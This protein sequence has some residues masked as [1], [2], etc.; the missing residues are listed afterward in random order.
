M[1]LLGKIAER[2][3]AKVGEFMA[4]HLEPG[5]TLVAALPMTQDSKAAMLGV[6][7]GPYFGLA[8][9]DRRLFVLKWR[10]TVPE[11][12]EEVLVAAPLSSVRV[13]KWSRPRGPITGNL[14]LDDGQGGRLRV[15]VPGIHRTD[16]EAL[17]SVLP[18]A[19]G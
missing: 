1:G 10:N 15:T 12:I 4:S 7:L 14:T 2:R 6:R 8:A 5:E 3:R 13:A 9:S 18:G 17:V 16:G 11:T 19:A